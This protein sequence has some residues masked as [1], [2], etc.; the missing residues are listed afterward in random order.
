[1]RLGVASGLPATWP[2]GTCCCC[3]A[4][5]FTGCCC[6]C[7]TVRVGVEAADDEAPELVV[8][9]VGAILDFLMGESGT[10]G[11]AVVAMD[12]LIGF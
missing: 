7:L 2:P 11:T 10:V 1:M 5:G 6:C 8:V 3:L 4:W 12:L 9:E